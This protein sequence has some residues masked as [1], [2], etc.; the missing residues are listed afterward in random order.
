MTDIINYHNG[1]SINSDIIRVL[2]YFNKLIVNVENAHRTVINAYKIYDVTLEN[3]QPVTAKVNGC[4]CTSNHT[5]CESASVIKD[6]NIKAVKKCVCVN[7]A[8]G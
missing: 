3:L 6:E 1:I 4:K 8:H 7:N 2:G 5:N